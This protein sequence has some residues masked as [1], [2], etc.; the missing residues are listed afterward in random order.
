MNNEGLHVLIY[1]AP[2]IKTVI[3]IKHCTDQI[4]REKITI[5]F[6]CSHL[7]SHYLEINH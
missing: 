1:V 2:T 3:K 5:V 4:D 7:S 6:M